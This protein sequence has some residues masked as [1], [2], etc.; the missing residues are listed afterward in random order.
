MKSSLDDF[1]LYLSSEKGL[2]LNTLEAYRRDLEKFCLYLNENGVTQFPFVSQ[3][4]IVNFLSVLKVGEYA[5]SSICRALIA[6]KVLFRFLKREKVVDTN[7]AL[8]LETPKIWQLIPEVLS[9]EEVDQLLDAPKAEEMMG[10]RDRAILEVLYS[11]GLRVSE[12]CGLSL[13]SIDDNYVRVIGKGRKERVVP[14]SKRAVKAVDHYLTH[15]RSQFDSEK[16]THL[17]LTKNGL[18]IDR[19][20]VWRFIKAYAKKAGIRKSIS[21]HTLRHSFA[22]HLLDHGADLRIIQEMLGH[23]S[24]SSTDRYTHISRT[25]LKESFERFSPNYTE[26]YC[27]ERLPPVK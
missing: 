23:S 3:E 14:I 10:A 6:I 26:S 13:Y 16:E 17:F 7:T 20:L 5:S 11:S 4:N 1:F 8:Y 22:T 21:P 2:S 9:H 25:H 24:I 12:V 19:V 27:R 18:P 15:Y